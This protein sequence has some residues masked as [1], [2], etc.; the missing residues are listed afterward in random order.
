MAR[1][2]TTNS[3]LRDMDDFAIQL[4]KRAR[5]ASVPKAS[6]EE[7]GEPS[8]SPVEAEIAEQVSVFTAVTRWVQT[9]HK[10]DPDDEP[11]SGFD[12]LAQRLSKSNKPNGAASRNRRGS[13]EDTGGVVSEPPTS[14][15]G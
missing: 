11:N 9:K 12:K 5:G 1:R 13:K 8:Q 6:G 4:L 14:G 15:D 2:R 10:I 7:G 3:L